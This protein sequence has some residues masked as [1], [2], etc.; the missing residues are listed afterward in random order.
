MSM[1][2]QAQ[3][4]RVLV[5]IAEGTEEM[6]AVITVDVLRRAG[7]AVTLASVSDSLLVTCSRGVKLVA[8]ALIKDVADDKWDLV[9][10]PG[11]MPG[12]EK[13]RDSEILENIVRTQANSGGLYAAI[14]ATPAGKVQGHLQVLSLL[15]LFTPLHSTLCFCPLVFLEAKGL[16]PGKRGTAHPAF[17]QELSDQSSVESRVVVDGNLTTS[18]GP[19]TAFEFALSLVSQLYGEEKAEEVAKPMVMK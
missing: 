12:A 9:A 1:I 3:A 14:C 5:P 10:L 17:S 11:G 13:L 19:G 4:K 18:R 7:A 2:I 16:M 15:L 8:D 6:E